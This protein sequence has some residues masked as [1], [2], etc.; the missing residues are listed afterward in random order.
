MHKYKITEIFTSFQ[1]EGYHMGKRAT[2]IRFHGCNLRC[3][4]CDTDLSKPYMELTAKEIA[5]KI[6]CDF[7][8]LT[9]GEPTL[10]NLEQLVEELGQYIELP[11]LAIETNGTGEVP[12]SI[13]WI[14]VSPKPGMDYKVKPSVIARADEYKYVIDKDFNISIL[15]HSVEAWVW[16]QPQFFDYENSVKRI[17]E[18]LS[19]GSNSSWR[20]GIQAHKYWRVE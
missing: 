14:T 16:L 8:V 15:P 1:G 20:F 11:Y 9:G 13:D 4:W 19:R 18:I 17:K 7:V 5:D 10:Q 12:Y 2:F 3:P 6:E